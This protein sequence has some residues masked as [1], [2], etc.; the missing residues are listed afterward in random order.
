M[1]NMPKPIRDVVFIEADPKKNAIKHL[2][3]GVD[4]IIDTAFEPHATENVTQDGV[5]LQPPSKLRG[6]ERVDLKA[7]DKVYTH[8]F[9]CD[10]DQSLELE[11][12]KFY[13]L[14]Y[15]MCYCR[16]REGKMKMLGDWN[17]IEP[18]KKEKEKT[19]NS[20]IIYNL[21]PASKEPQVGI[22]RHINEKMRE[23]GVSEGDSVYFTINSDYE[24]LVEGKKYWRMRN[25]DIIGI[26]E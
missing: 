3:P 11:G 4:I 26:K 16:I 8:H 1:D 9:L 5:V 7:G 22:A 2:A 20:G 15:Q 13:Q 12:K 21:A 10:E 17:F 24:I 18:P 23:W 14:A 19:T 25:V 6:G